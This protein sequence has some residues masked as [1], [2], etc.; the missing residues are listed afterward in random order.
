MKDFMNI[1]QHGHIPVD[2][3]STQTVI[4]LPKL[5]QV[6]CVCVVALAL[7]GKGQGMAQIRSEDEGRENK[8]KKRKMRRE[9]REY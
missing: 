7:A 1:Q 4:P 9:P 6:G 2:I 3:K 8:Q 5:N